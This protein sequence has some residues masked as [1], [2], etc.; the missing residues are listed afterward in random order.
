MSNLAFSIANKPNEGTYFT[1][2][3]GSLSEK[4]TQANVH[5]YFSKFGN[6][7]ASNLITDW[8]TGT[9]KRCAIVFIASRDVYC[10]I[11]G[12]PKHILDGKKIRVAVA[13]QDKK[14]TKKISTNNL[15][16]GNIPS[17]CSEGMLKGLFQR[18]GMILGIRF[19]RNVSTKP[20]TKNAIIEFTNSKSV[21]TAFKHKASLEIEGTPLK[22]SP[23]KQKKTGT[24]PN[25]EQSDNQ[26]GSCG[27]DD[28]QFP[29]GWEGMVETDND[30]V[31][32]PEMPAYESWSEGQQ[33]FRSGVSD[34]FQFQQAF[35]SPS[36]TFTQVGS[37]YVESN[38]EK[39]AY[40]GD[41]DIESPGVSS[42]RSTNT[43]ETDNSME[44]IAVD[45]TFGHYIT[46]IDVYGDDEISAAFFKESPLRKQRLAYKTS[47]KLSSRIL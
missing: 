3:V 28:D 45:T 18:F 22:I 4:S 13:D 16:V 46:L 5:R 39:N 26:T 30:F 29:E 7:L 6:I 2:F 40:H 21:E 23:L 9:S 15:F 38:A 43:E 8:T 24:S 36:D 37:F 10:R 14:G 27:I 1:I 42:K 34:E 31:C 12:C 41:S 32:E 25:Q 47:Q 44:D 17:S 20:N 11:L 35:N 19:F 33:D